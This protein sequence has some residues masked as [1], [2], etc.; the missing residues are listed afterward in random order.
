MLRRHLK[1]ALSLT[2]LVSMGA[3]HSDAQTPAKAPCGTDYRALDF[4]I[5]EWTVA[6]GGKKVSEVIVE[7]TL[8]GCALAE[9]W[10]GQ[11]TGKA[12]ATFNPDAKAWEYF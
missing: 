4:W 11:S 5:G 6:N 9:M 2:A 10:R 8:N 12:L 1:I 7:L 3:I